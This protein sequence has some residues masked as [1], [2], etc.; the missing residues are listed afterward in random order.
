MIKSILTSPMG[1]ELITSGG[2]KANESIL[3][4][5]LGGARI[6]K[7]QG[8]TIPTRHSANI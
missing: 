8:Q 4:K 1:F 6:A 7:T 3:T 2:L 5:G